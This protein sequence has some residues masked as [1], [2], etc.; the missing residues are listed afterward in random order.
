MEIKNNEI[1]ISQE[2]L[3]NFSGRINSLISGFDNIST[4]VAMLP[5]VNTLLYET[6]AP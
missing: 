5:S 2:Y 4:Q 3:S 1:K 6:E